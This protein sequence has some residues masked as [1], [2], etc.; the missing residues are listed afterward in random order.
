MIVLSQE[1][2]KR[3]VAVHGWSGTLLGLLLYAVVLTGAV[4]VFAHEIGSWSRGGDATRYGLPSNVHRSLDAR[5]G[6]VDP[7][8]H[9]EVSIGTT[10]AG[11][12]RLSF[13]KHMTNPETGQVEDHA[14]VFH[15]DPAS[16]E[17]LRHQEGFLRA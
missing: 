13:Q 1:R 11:A 9:A 4:A 12:L 7:A 2:T 8:Y 5:M 16:G 3:L 6:M 17:T 15:V 14:H 10:D